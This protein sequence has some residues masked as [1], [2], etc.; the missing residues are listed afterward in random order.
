MNISFNTTKDSGPEA[1]KKFFVTLK[2]SHLFRKIMPFWSFLQKRGNLPSSRGKEEI[3]D[4]HKPE[5]EYRGKRGRV[6]GLTITSYRSFTYLVTSVTFPL[7]RILTS[8][9]LSFDLRAASRSIFGPWI[10]E[11]PPVTAEKSRSKEIQRKW[12]ILLKME[13]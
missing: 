6:R 8:W 2:K 11:F 7:K 3:S 12:K 1:Q 13:P 5:E 9:A 4:S 10:N